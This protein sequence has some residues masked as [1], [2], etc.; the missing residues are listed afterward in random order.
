M[1]N[2]ENLNRLFPKP[3]KR[4]HDID[5]DYLVE[6][7]LQS[8]VWAH[9]LS[10]YESLVPQVI[11]AGL[12]SVR[13]EAPLVEVSVVLADNDFVRQLNRGYRGRDKPT[14]VLS[15][16]ASAPQYLIQ[17]TGQP[18]LLGDIV[19]AFE[20]VLEEAAAQHKTL[21]EH[22]AHLIVHGTLHLLGYDH[23]DDEGAREMEG[24]EIEILA[25]IDITNPYN[26]RI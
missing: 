3:I 1:I 7:R 21:W 16:P 11:N 13:L 24:L 20:T 18:F 22:T 4:E 23:E 2:K 5:K 17:N 25:K 14:N 6:I 12:N 10:D 15:F 26:C 8:Q 9:N 19:L